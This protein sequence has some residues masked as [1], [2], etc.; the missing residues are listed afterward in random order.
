[1]MATATPAAVTATATTLFCAG[2]LISEPSKRICFTG[3]S[4]RFQ[5][6]YILLFDMIFNCESLPFALL[7]KRII[8]KIIIKN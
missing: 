4:K 5:G 8:V 6:D 2:A 3:N 7:K 1:M